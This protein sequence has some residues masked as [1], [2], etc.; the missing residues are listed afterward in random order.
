MVPVQAQLCSVCCATVT[1]MWLSVLA[2]DCSG[3]G[4]GL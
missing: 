4:L 1:V 2:G 3:T